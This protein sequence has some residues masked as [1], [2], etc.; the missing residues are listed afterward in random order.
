MV[1]SPI[2]DT[3]HIARYCRTKQ[4]EEGF[5]S[6]IAFHLRP[7]DKDALSVNWM[8]FFTQNKKVVTPS[9]RGLVIDQI[10]ICI[11]M[12]R[13][14]NGPFAI[15]NVGVAKQAI[16]VGGGQSPNVWSTPQPAKPAQGKRSAKGPD[17]SHASVY[18]Y[19]VDN[20][21]D[22]AVQLLALVGPG[23]VFPKLV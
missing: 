13:P 20:N 6:V 9:E 17:P 10:R 15:L 19:T 4:T 21:L 3:H 7:T 14:L 8:E 23:D 11:Q 1:G 18:G 16:V 5:P 2:P 22:V 12:D